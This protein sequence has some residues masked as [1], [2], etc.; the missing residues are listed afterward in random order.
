MV[1]VHKC[2]LVHMYVCMC[3]CL[4]AKL[5]NVFESC[6]CMLGLGVYSSREEGDSRELVLSLHCGRVL[7]AEL[8]FLAR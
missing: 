6:T 4:K 1:C 3:A 5:G 8:R 2:V 7:R